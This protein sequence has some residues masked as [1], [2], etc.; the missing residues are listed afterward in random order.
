MTTIEPCDSDVADAAAP[1]VPSDSAPV[2]GGVLGRTY[3]ALTLGIISVVSLIA[4]EASAVNTAMPVAAR[5]LDGIE[6]Y[7]FAFSAYFT[8]S[9]FSMA[10]SGAW[11]DRN[12]PLAPLFSGIFTFGGGLVLAGAA[13]TMWTF[14]AGR[15]VQGLGGGLVI[16]A[17]YVVV[18]RAYPERL[19]PAVL[20]SF[21]A[22][23]VL[24]VIV[25]PVVSGTV[26][27]HA[28]WRW[29]FLSIPVLVLLPVAVMLPALRKL[30]RREEGE[31]AASLDRRRILLALAVATG[32]GLLQYAGQDLRPLA[33][34]PAAAG[35][36]LLVP[37]VLRLL[38]KGTFRAARGLPSVVLIRGLAAGALLAAES[39]VPLMLV[40][41][42][43][44]SPTLA[45]L[46]LTGGGLTWA[47]GS[48]TQS[49]PR[50]E[51]YRERLMCVGMLLMALAVAL[52]PLAL[53][54]TVPAAVVAG[55]WVIAGFG[56][57]LTIS[58]GSVLL[59]KLSRPEDAGR[60]SASL[61]VSDALGNI[62]FVGISG[63]LFIAF[64]GG[65]VATARP[66]AHAGASVAAHPAAFAAVFA[67]MSLVALVGAYV[68]TRLRPVPTAPPAPEPAV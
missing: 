60:N 58:S 9:L 20:A 67:A 40:T 44:L 66:G 61:Q 43:G 51:P 57:G 34:L 56:M 16:V 30:P 38:P 49:R 17:L 25:G 21:S 3:R 6:L 68:A 32:A 14:V 62:T 64:G 29:V 52:V 37:S 11:C 10:L 19:R 54:D 22:A 59:L 1:D 5:A 4:F 55:A 36:A 48:Y 31:D 15:A 13:P 18:S 28:G 47:L 26:T 24:P 41:Q 50:L 12:G 23:W 35:L 45:G 65:A 42:R 8:A 33:L 2:G 53:V 63:I 7:A 39:F 46:S 27:E